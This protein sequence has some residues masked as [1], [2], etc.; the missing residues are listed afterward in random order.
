MFLRLKKP[1]G[2]VLAVA[3]A[4]SWLYIAAHANWSQNERTIAEGHP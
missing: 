3:L 1:L 2:I 4:A